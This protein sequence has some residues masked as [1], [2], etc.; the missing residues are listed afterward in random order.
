MM[1]TF[2]SQATYPPPPV[3]LFPNKSHTTTIFPIPLSKKYYQGFFK[4]LNTWQYFGDM[5]LWE[6]IEH[7]TAYFGNTQGACCLKKALFY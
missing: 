1:L 6:K 2:L 3:L 4:K 5:D 7:I